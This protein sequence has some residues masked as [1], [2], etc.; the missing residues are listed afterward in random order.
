MRELMDEISRASLCYSSL[1]QNV[2]SSE[3]IIPNLLG[4]WEMDF[5]LWIM[6][7]QVGLQFKLS[8]LKSSFLLVVTL[9]NF[10]ILDVITID[11]SSCPF[12]NW[13]RQLRS[14]LH[15]LI[16]TRDESRNKLEHDLA[17]H[18]NKML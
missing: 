6:Q 5:F 4:E 15:I 13:E 12:E 2:F 16:S 18:P 17:P 14:S 7:V 3:F 10:S 1:Q 8:V 9:S 11:S